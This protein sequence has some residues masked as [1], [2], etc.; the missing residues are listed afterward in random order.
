M[1]A[2][3]GS[4]DE[5]RVGRSTC[6]LG[7]DPVLAHKDSADELD[8][9]LTAG[10]GAG[11]SDRSREVADSNVGSA[12]PSVPIT[13]GSSS[14]A[15]VNG[16]AVASGAIHEFTTRIIAAGRFGRGSALPSRSTCQR[17]PSEG[18]QEPLLPTREVL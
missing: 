7:S 5:L 2:L 15:L 10:G 16:R 6:N 13:S 3:S 4:V 9:K 11:G 8:G 12:S 14:K 17:L 18:K 1:K